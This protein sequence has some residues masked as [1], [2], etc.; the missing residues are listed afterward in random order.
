MISVSNVVSFKNI[1]SH[2]TFAVF[3]VV[4]FLGKII[5]CIV[6]SIEVVIGCQSF[7]YRN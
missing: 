3:I 4:A 1:N 7:I 6:F 2:G 5:I